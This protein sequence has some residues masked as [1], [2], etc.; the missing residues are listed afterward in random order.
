MKLFQI[1]KVLRFGEIYKNVL[2]K[3]IYYHFN[4]NL[5]ILEMKILSKGQL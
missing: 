2:L 3:M 5:M 1:L 4:N